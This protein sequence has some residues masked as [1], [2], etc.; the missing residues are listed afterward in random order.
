MEPMSRPSL[1]R[2]LLRVAAVTALLLLVPAIAMLFTPQVAW[3]P[4]DFVAAAALLF[5][6]GALSVLG[7]RLV[8]GAGWRA[9]VIIGIALVAAAIWAELAVGILR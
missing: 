8:R 5:G 2:L 6:A 1:K 9:A 7:L 3:G 4:P